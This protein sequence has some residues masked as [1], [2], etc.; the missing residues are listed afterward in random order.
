MVQA[1][2]EHDTA[3]HGDGAGGG[4]S[5]L[6]TSITTSP[7]SKRTDRRSQMR[8]NAS[9]SLKDVFMNSFR[10]TNS[11]DEDESGHCSFHKSARRVFQI[12]NEKSSKDLFHESKFDQD[13]KN[14]I[15]SQS[16]IG[17][18]DAS[19][20]S[21]NLQSPKTIHE[22]HAEEDGQLPKKKV[23]VSF[24]NVE[25]REYPMIVGD[26]P[27]GK[28][29]CPVTIDWESLPPPVIVELDAY[30]Y[31]RAPNRRHR[32]EQMRMNSTKRERMLQDLGFGLSDRQ[33]GRKEANMVRKH[34][35][36]TNMFA[37]HKFVDK[38]METVEGMERRLLSALTMGRYKK[39]ERDYLKKNVPNYNDIIVK[40]KRS[41]RGAAAG[42]TTTPG[43]ETSLSSTTWKQQ[44]FEFAN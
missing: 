9:M 33:W 39:E 11:G 30:E 28:F 18:F 37:D 21:L 15:H 24:H 19:I 3:D 27:G 38:T 7:R 25:V 17:G 5:L 29:G 41:S 16:Q 23:R 20:A 6:M 10:L 14:I 22:D 8:K 13:L 12:E 35:K 31:I 40:Q 42:A 44:Q 1:I 4:S 32:Q 43:S 34:R 26:N 2:P 36:Q